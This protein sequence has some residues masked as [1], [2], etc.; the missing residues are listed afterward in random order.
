[1][2][3][4]LVSLLCT[5]CFAGAA[6][7]VSLVEHPAR[8]GCGAA[9]ALAEFR[10]SYRR[11]AVM[12]A[13]LAVV[14]ALSAIGAWALGRG[15]V[16]LIA[17]VLLG[18]A[19]PYTLLVILPTNKRLLDPSLRPDSPVAEGLLARWGRMHAVRTACGV[20]SFVL[21]AIG[22]ARG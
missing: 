6:V 20:A 9:V 7:Y 17:G 10:P 2:I 12:Q 14:G 1:M 3:L 18:A 15:V 8:M 13:S 21:L 11:G 16:P 5:G 4:E 19:I 22:L